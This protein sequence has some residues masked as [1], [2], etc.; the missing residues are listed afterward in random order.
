[1]ISLYRKIR[2]EKSEKQSPSPKPA[3][4]HQRD[5]F[6]TPSDTLQVSTQESP[7]RE[8]LWGAQ[9][10]S[11]KPHDEAATVPHDGS[12]SESLP[13]PSNNVNCQACRDEKVAARKYRIKLLVGLLFPFAIQALDVTIVASA[14]PWIAK[15]FDKVSQLNWIVSAFNLTSA[16]FV[17]F[18]GQMADVYGRHAALQATVT[19][20]M[21]GSALCT[22]APT[23]AF[24]LLLLGRGI[25]GLGC[26]GISVII[27]VILADKVSLKEN[28]KNWSI[29]QL[30][31]GV[32][33][34]LGPVIG[35][36]LTSTAWR[37]CFAINLPICVVAIVVIFFLLRKELLGPQDLAQGIPTQLQEATN[38]AVD[39]PPMSPAIVAAGAGSRLSRFWARFT[40]VDAGG[41]LLFLFGFGLIVLA[42]T[43]AGATYSWDSVA[44]LTPLLVG[45]ALVSAFIFWERLMAPG[46]ALAAKLPRQKPMLPWHIFTTKD[47]GLLCFINFATGTAM[48][49]VL[50]FCSI[51]FTM[52]KLYNSD[53]AG[54]QLLY[55]TPGLGV[56]VYASMFLCNKYPRKTFFPTMLGSIIEAI[57]V[58]MLAWALYSES[59][60]TIYGMM[61]VTGVGTGLRL[62]S[63]QLH[64][65]GFFPR[66][67]A[68]V[69]SLLSVTLPFGGTLG[70]TIMTTVFNN[71]SG[72]NND[73]PVRNFDVLSSLPEAQR[74]IVTQQAKMG[75]V[76]AFVSIMPIMVLCVIAASLLG[77]VDI[78]ADGDESH[79][80]RGVYLLHL[81]R[82]R[83][84][85]VQS[86]EPQMELKSLP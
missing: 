48:Y 18:W 7:S 80:F 56:G 81:F 44:V 61:A 36:Y 71:K 76:W 46:R 17:P 22:A 20:M 5:V 50:Y 16:A 57:G 41:Q 27:R 2:K 13:A 40:T 4:A 83:R 34:S 6:T 14:L 35:G 70:L 77:N 64:A 75:V 45:V 3:C 9:H 86:E 32:S 54:V 59:I 58:G 19:I 28:A 11:I 21:I 79:V 12:R 15:D 47:V 72:I 63:V 69:V 65:V 73:S 23:N 26:A 39:L 62:L 51:Y 1:M 52:V 74:S 55:Y 10:S 82:R 30:T 60:P 38:A 84:E 8:A 24:P 49:S 53:Q 37:W 78:A 43:W 68:T 31:A 67:I 29:F 66:S 33:Y 85:P 42:M 25:Q